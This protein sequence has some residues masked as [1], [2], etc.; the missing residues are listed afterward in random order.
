MPRLA[1]AHATTPHFMN[2]P[3]LQTSSPAHQGHHPDF[4]PDL[5]LSTPSRTLS[6]ASPTFSPTTPSASLLFLFMAPANSSCNPLIS[7]FL[8]CVS[9]IVS[10]FI[11]PKYASWYV[12]SAPRK[13]FRIGAEK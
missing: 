7:V 4:F 6:L 8:S 12:K 11:H 5:T 10:S 2:P 3:H 13:H 9:S 1:P